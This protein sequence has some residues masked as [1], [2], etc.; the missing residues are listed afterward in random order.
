MKNVTVLRVACPL[1]FI[2]SV[3]V[4]RV[5]LNPTPSLISNEGGLSNFLYV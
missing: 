2:V 4:V 5:R 3:T 1:H